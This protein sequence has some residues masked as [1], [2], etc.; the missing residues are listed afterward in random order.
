EYGVDLK[1]TIPRFFTPFYTEGIVP[2]YMS[3]STRISLSTTSQTNI[4][5]DKQTFNGIVSFNWR[6]SLKVT[7]RLDIFNLQY[8]RNLDIVRYFDVY[9]TSFNSLNQIAKDVNYIDPNDD[10][11]TEDADTFIAYVL[12]VP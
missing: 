1:L 11:I 8:V 6:P 5:L 4:G 7:N 9:R 12:G 10:L 3:P 2:K